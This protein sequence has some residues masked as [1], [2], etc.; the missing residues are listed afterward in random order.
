MRYQVMLDRQDGAG[1]QQFFETEQ[2]DEAKFL[3]LLG[4]A[5]NTAFSGAMPVE[6]T[7]RFARQTF[8]KAFRQ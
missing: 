5:V 6:D 3:G 2:F 4:L 1:F 7:L 8:D